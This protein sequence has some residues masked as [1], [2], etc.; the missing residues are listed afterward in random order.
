MKILKK[1]GQILI[2]NSVLVMCC[3][4]VLSLESATTLNG[5]YDPAAILVVVISIAIAWHYIMET[6]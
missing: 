3:V 4:G 2:V 1:L 6:P 5:N